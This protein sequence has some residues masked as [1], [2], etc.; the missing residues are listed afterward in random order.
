VTLQQHQ[1]QADQPQ[2]RHPSLLLHP[3]QQGYQQ[4]Q[5]LTQALLLL[6]IYLWGPVRPWLLPPYACWV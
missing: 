1:L 6:L 3:H 5:H 2:L 4:Q